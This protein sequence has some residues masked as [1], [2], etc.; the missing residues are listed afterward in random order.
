MRVTQQQIAQRLGVS[1]TL[2][3]YALNDKGRISDELKARILEEA[4]RSGYQPNKAAR[5]LRSGRSKL[6]ALCLPPYFSPFFGLVLIKLQQL[7]EDSGYDLMTTSG[8]TPQLA[9]WPLDG[10]LFYDDSPV[11]TEEIHRTISGTGVGQTPF[12]AFGHQM[13]LATNQPAYKGV[14]YIGVD[15]YGASVRVVQSLIDSGCRRPAF[16]A[17]A[18][19]S[20]PT[21]ARLSAFRCVMRRA[22]LEGREI[23]VPDSATL[24]QETKNVLM[25]LLA[26]GIPFDG[27]FCGNDDVA[28]GALRALR[29]Q[30]I[31]VPSQVQVAGCDGLPDGAEA[32]PSLSTIR[33]PIEAMCTRAWET[34]LW[35]LETPEAPVHR[36][37][38]QPEI[39]WR[40][41]GGPVT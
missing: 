10:I 12:V 23:V 11:R 31:E 8:R 27:L 21:E 6:V 14:D 20:Q 1:Q 30:K 28:L 35:R 40:E 3:G 9:Q 18:S 33:L 19:I 32:E 17:A 34:L 36:E 25:P 15:L 37:V 16:A 5:A 4:R 7:A 13:D 24:R 26:E 22:G 41:S 38:L 39:V 29:A 2:V